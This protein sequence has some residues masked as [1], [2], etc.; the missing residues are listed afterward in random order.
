MLK[1]FY[2]P[3]RYLIAQ[4]IFV[5]SKF[6][7]CFYTSLFVFQVG[8]Y[9]LFLYQWFQ[10]KIVDALSNRVS[11]SSLPINISYFGI[12]TDQIINCLNIFHNPLNNPPDEH[13]CL[14]IITLP[15]NHRLRFIYKFYLYSFLIWLNLL[16][17]HPQLQDHLPLHSHCRYF[18]VLSS[19]SFSF[20][21]SSICFT[22]FSSFLTCAHNLHRNTI[23]KNHRQILWNYLYSPHLHSIN[24]QHL[25]HF[26]RCFS[27]LFVFFIRPLILMFSFRVPFLLINYNQIII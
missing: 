4:K 9:Q 7:Q 26:N 17:R 23:I 15:H 27:C 21:P 1:C 16:T 13:P 11:H 25:I 12:L 14:R 3:L 24:L 18:F 8:P 6:Y 20:C 19:F 2:L 22:Y 10:R 5:Y